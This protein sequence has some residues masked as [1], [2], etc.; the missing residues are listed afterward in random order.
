MIE[1]VNGVEQEPTDN[2]PNAILDDAAQSYQETVAKSEG[3]NPILKSL[4][5]GLE[6][7]G[8]RANDVEN[9]LTP[10]IEKRP[11]NTDLVTL[12]PNTRHTHYQYDVESQPMYVAKNDTP[13]AQE[14]AN[15]AN[16]ANHVMHMS[17]ASSAVKTAVMTPVNVVTGLFNSAVVIGSHT[18]GMGI[19][20]LKGDH[21]AVAEKNKNIG[22]FG[23]SIVQFVQN[24]LKPVGDAINA[25]RDNFEKGEY[26]KSGEQAGALGANLAMTAYSVPQLVKFSQNA[27]KG[28]GK[29]TGAQAAS[30]ADEVVVAANQVQPAGKEGLQGTSTLP[31]EQPTALIEGLRR[32]SDHFKHLLQEATLEFNKNQR[33]GL[34]DNAIEILAV[35]INSELILYKTELVLAVIDPSKSS[36]AYKIKLLRDAEKLLNDTAFAQDYGS[37]IQY[38]G[39]QVSASDTFLMMHKEWSEA[40]KAANALSDY[41]KNSEP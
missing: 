26:A 41:L 24:P 31:A 15:F 3:E 34:I 7:L 12:H 1:G 37:S 29:K 21:Q 10:Q 14:E 38:S 32:N 22:N 16:R 8:D 27:L 9:F 36:Q 11:I 35:K 19:D 6:W 4:Q 39:S 17:A 20:Q 40:R 2:T 25:S 30:N 18:F 28:L 5:T 23:S 33:L 13:Q